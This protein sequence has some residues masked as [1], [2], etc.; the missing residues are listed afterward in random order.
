[1]SLLGC[2]LATVVVAQAE[3]YKTGTWSAATAYVTPENRVETGLFGAT[4]MG[5]GD[6]LE[7]SSHPLWFFVIPNVAV[8]RVDWV[9]GDAVLSSEHTLT[10]PTPL[11]KLLSREG[12][13][14]LLPH[15]SRVPH[16]V[17][18]TNELLVT[19]PLG[20]GHALTGWLGLTLAGAVGRANVTTIDLPVVYPRMAAYYEHVTGNAGLSLAGPVWRKVTYRVDGELFLIPNRQAT[21]AAEADLEVSYTLGDTWQLMLGTKLAYSQLPYGSLTRLLPMLDVRY[22]F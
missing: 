1:M 9:L 17:A 19:Q 8:K 3:A 14:G 15:E 5:L 2:V 18:L 21:W 10:Y 4:R 22:A 12:V 7:L 11:L 16:I 6:G 20:F 13:G